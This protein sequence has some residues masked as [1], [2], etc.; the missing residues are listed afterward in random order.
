[1]WIV[2]LYSNISDLY[3][4]HEP[5]NS[6]LTRECSDAKSNIH[7]IVRK[8]SEIFNISTYYAK[9][10]C[11]SYYQ[12]CVSPYGQIYRSTSDICFDYNE[13]ETVSR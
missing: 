12:S 8:R 3:T 11:I 13:M 7:L 2:L 1:M 5:S 10:T 6:S 4:L 9:L